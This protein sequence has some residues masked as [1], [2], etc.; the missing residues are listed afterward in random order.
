MT[1]PD[2]LLLLWNVTETLRLQFPVCKKL[3]GVNEPR[4]ILASFNNTQDIKQKV[5]FP[6]YN[7]VKREICARPHVVHTGEYVQVTKM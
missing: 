3:L 2:D 6:Y 5:R 7:T 4:T 1:Y